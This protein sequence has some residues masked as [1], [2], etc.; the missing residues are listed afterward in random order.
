MTRSQPGSDKTAA[1]LRA[2]G[3]QPFIYPLLTITPISPLPKLPPDDAVLLF[4][5]QN[6]LRIFCE[7]FP[8][9]QW[10]V[11]TVGDATAELASR[12]GFQ[13]VTSAS[14]TS[15][16]LI[17]LVQKAVP[18]RGTPLVHSAGEIVRGQICETLQAQGYSAKR[19]IYY[20]SKPQTLPPGIDVSRMDYVLLHSPLAAKTLCAGLPD[21]GD[22]VIICISDETRQALG[23][24]LAAASHIAPE[25][26]EAS[27]FSLLD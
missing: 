1:A 2:I 23:P 16:D 6:A 18:D 15:N 25:P 8:S 13:D 4:T 5:S 17:A 24:D 20:A 19:D 27:M 22:A 7:S 26:N 11:L 21:I 9:R 10:R 3:H 12:A 14:G